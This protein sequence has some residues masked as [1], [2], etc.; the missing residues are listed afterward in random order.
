MR[1][2]KIQTKLE[3]TAMVIKGKMPLILRKE[4]VDGISDALGIGSFFHDIYPFTFKFL[5]LILL[6]LLVGGA[7]SAFRRNLVAV[8]ELYAPPTRRSVSVPLG[9]IVISF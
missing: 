5:Y 9:D 3:D 7:L 4:I 8:G 6:Y 1:T 2:Y